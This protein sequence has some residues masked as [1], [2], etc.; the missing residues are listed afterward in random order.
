[1]PDRTQQTSGSWNRFAI[2]VED[3]SDVAE[4]LQKAGVH[5]RNNIVSVVGGKQSLLMI[6]QETRLNYLNR[7]WRKRGWVGNKCRLFVDNAVE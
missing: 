5:F 3:I 6:L 4:S 7:F 1:M 2:E